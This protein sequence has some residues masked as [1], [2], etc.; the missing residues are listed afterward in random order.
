MQ[1]DAAFD[2]R[3]IPSPADL[4]QTPLGHDRRH[5]TGAARSDLDYHA[6]AGP[7]HSVELAKRLL[8]RKQMLKNH[9]LKL[10]TLRCFPGAVRR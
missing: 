4:H 2:P 5:I 1:Q 3:Q 6:A 8:G 7:E 10:P 9:D